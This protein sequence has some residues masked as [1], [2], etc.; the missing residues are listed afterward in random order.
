MM[1]Q[2]LVS[3]CIP[4]FNSAKYIKKSIISICQQTYANIEIII[5]DNASTDGTSDIV[6][7]INDE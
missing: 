4:T 1:S 5:G 2:I 6:Q 3:I 7:G